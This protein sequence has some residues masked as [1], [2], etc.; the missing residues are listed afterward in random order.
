MPGRLWLAPGPRR[1]AHRC[2]ADTWP[3]QRTVPGHPADR[4]PG[5]GRAIHVVRRAR[6]ACPTVPGSDVLHANIQDRFT[7][8][9]VQ[10]MS[11]RFVTDP[12]A[13]KVFPPD[14]W[15]AAPPSPDGAW[16]AGQ[17]LRS[18]DEALVVT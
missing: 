5:L 18:V 9:G 14:H 12:Q 15:Y 7:E 17:I 11:L 16:P 1:A 13:P 2:E 10:M 6:A 8:H 3:A 4:S